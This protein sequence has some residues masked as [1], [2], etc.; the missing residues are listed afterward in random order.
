MLKNKHEAYKKKRDDAKLA[1]QRDDG[2]K[3]EP[4]VTQYSVRSDRPREVARDRTAAQHRDSS[5]SRGCARSRSRGRLRDMNDQL[6]TLTRSVE[7]MSNA[8]AA[9]SSASAAS[10]SAADVHIL[11]IADGPHCTKVL[12]LAKKG[13]QLT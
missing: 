3:R 2:R 11:K 5:R 12:S 7:Q 4:P 10:A 13:L 9:S 8:M 1:K 6:S